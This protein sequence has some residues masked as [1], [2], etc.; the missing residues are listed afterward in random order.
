MNNPPPML[1]RWDAVFLAILI[2]VWLG[3]VAAGYRSR[4]RRSLQVLH[5]WAKDNHFHIVE[6]RRSIMNMHLPNGWLVRVYDVEIV[7]SAARERRG[8]V[9]VGEMFWGF[10]RERVYVDWASDQDLS[11]GRRTAT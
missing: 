9:V 4:T 6:F 11:Q 3:F 2:A 1:V 8:R 7:D 5:E 10:F